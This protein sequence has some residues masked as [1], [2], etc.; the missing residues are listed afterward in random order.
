MFQKALTFNDVLL[1]PAYSNILPSQVN[2]ETQLGPRL[3]L[4]MPIL[5]AAMDTVT[6]SRMAIAMSE[7]GGLGIIH[8]N[9]S[10]LRQAQKV[11]QVFKADC[12]CGGAV[13]PGEDL[14][15]RAKSL[16]D[17]GV[18][19]LVLDTAHGHSRGVIEGVQKLKTWFPEVTVIA[20]N[21]ATRAA[22]QALIEAGADVLKVGI[23]PGSICTTRIVAGVGVPQLTAVLEVA[24]IARPYGV[25]VIAD[26]GIKQS[27]D[28]TKALAA[29]A[30]AVMLGSLLAGTKESPGDVIEIDGKYWKFYRGMGSLAAMKQ[31]SKDR[32]A[33]G[34]VSEGKKLVAEGVEARTAY[35]GEL[36][37]VLYQLIGGLRSGMGYLGAGNLDNL[38]KKAEFVQI[39][40]AGLVESHVHSVDMNH[41]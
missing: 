22:A 1:I 6:E 18:S 24:A 12:R 37:S 30:D 3:K 21:I 13:G 29:G 10:P 9:L 28:I 25:G 34:D 35:V 8:K 41:A 15:L 11:A 19:V 7:L 38:R 32:Y 33:Q 4:A 23:G 2:V 20:G 14:E 31:G 36:N 16:V 40:P 17:A 39:T 27:G 5:S 26:G